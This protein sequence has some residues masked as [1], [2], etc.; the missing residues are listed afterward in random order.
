VNRLGTAVA[1]GN[2][3]YNLTYGY[4]AYGNGSCVMN[5]N[6]QGVCPQLTFDAATSHVTY[7]G[8]TPVNYD[9]A[10][11]ML[12]DETYG[13]QYD[14]EG[15]MVYASQGTWWES[16]LYNALGQRVTET[17]P[18]GGSYTRT[19]IY[20]RDIFGR[21][22]EIFD[23]W[24]SHGWAGADQ[25]WARVAGQRLLMGGST[26]YLRHADAVGSSTMLTDQTGAVDGDATFYPWGQV[27]QI[28]GGSDGTF[29]DLGFQVNYPLPPSATRDYNPT[30]GRWLV[31]DPAGEMAVNPANPQTW[32]MYAYVGDN[33]TTLNDPSGLDWVDVGNCSYD[34]ENSSAVSSK[35]SGVSY[36][37]TITPGYI[38]A[39]AGQCGGI[40]DGD[41]SA[42]AVVPDTTGQYRSSTAEIVAAELAQQ[43]ASRDVPLTP[44]QRFIFSHVYQ[45]TESLQSPWFPVAWY[46]ASGGLGLGGEELATD[47]Q[48]YAWL[49]EEAAPYGP[50]INT[51]GQFMQGLTTT[52]PV[53]TVPGLVGRAIKIGLGLMQ[54]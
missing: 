27:W 54:W 9:A 47:F 50:Q 35:I 42:P 6:T 24:P 34:I 7:I 51:V 3:T 16:S 38:A 23:D 26:S 28:S 46:G 13:Y 17:M 53:T 32:N 15:R 48:G 41:L 22:T 11:D 31:P 25:Y 37:A 52:Q 8:S 36:P 33:P 18:D 20:P 30:L 4:D 44:A 1:T 40:G 21:R 45:G 14:A 12:N 19:L 2:S 29:G 39:T 43:Y 49:E 5:Q 10:G